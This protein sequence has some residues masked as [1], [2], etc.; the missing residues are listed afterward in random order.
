MKIILYV[1]QNF[2]T[3]EGKLRYDVLQD[4]EDK[5]LVSIGV[6]G[7]IKKNSDLTSVLF[8]SDFEEVKTVSKEFAKKFFAGENFTIIEKDNGYLISFTGKID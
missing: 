3:S 7:F 4:S 5:S 2:L 6:K 8:E 1:D